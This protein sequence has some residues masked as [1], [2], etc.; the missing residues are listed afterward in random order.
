MTTRRQ[1]LVAIGA[2][3]LSPQVFPQQRAKTWRVAYLN[4]GNAEASVLQQQ[5]FLQ[6]L[7]ELGYIQGANLAFEAQSAESRMERLPALGEALLAGKPDVV[8][9]SNSTPTRVLMKLTRTVPI[10]F[11]RSADPVGTGLV[12]SLARPGGNVTG[13]SVVVVET[14]GKRIELLRELVPSARRF[15]FLGP[16]S[17]PGVGQVYAGLQAAARPL[18]VSVRALD[19]ATSADIER[20]FAS[21]DAEP[22][23]AL[24]TAGSAV[25]HRK[26][27]ADLSLRRKLPALYVYR[28]HLNAGGLMSFGPHITSAYRH[29]AEIVDR[30]LR[31][32]NPADL[33]VEQQTQYLAINMKTAKALGINV[34]RSLMARADEVIQ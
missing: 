16:F 6:R 29:A 7:R 3:T 24:I 23:D 30:I 18:G 1:L 34:P 10:V 9:A 28:E 33:P 32:A 8:V 31:G 4:D 19:A 11:A 15:G 26:Q 21:L 22:I 27:I 20:A 5:A 12:R 17:N 14:A 25:G 13:S 2:A